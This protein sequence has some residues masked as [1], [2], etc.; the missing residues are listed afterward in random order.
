MKCDCDTFW[1]HDAILKY[2]NNN[3]EVSLIG[4]TCINKELIAWTQGGCYFVRA[5]AADKLELDTERLEAQMART[6]RE[7][8]RK[9][10]E[11]CNE[12]LCVFLAVLRAKLPVELRYYYN[13]SLIHFC[14]RK[15][16]MIKLAQA[17]EG[18]HVY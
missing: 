3:E 12:D 14:E 2:V 5:G 7:W 17:T 8:H 15:N 6:F 10:G 11:C 9:P 18:V 4:N 1:L 16:E 13:D